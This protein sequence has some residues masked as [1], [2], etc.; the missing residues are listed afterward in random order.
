MIK[1]PA[2]IFED[3]LPTFLGAIWAPFEED[4]LRI[5]FSRAKYFIPVAVAALVARIDH[6]QRN[7][8]RF[9]PTGLEQCENVRYLQRIDFFEQLDVD[10]PENFRRHDPGTAFVPIREIEPGPV[11]L[12]N[13]PTATEL[14]RCVA[15]GD[16]N[17]AFYLSEYTL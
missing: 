17:Q 8:M 5:D 4:E 16:D 1:L 10:L 7:G 12:T 15:N 2:Y 11:R 13:D 14:A 9:A 6:P 3:S